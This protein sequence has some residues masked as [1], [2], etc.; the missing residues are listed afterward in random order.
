MDAPAAATVSERRLIT[1]L[2]AD[3]VGFTAMSEHLDPEDVS[4]LL[5]LYFTRCR[6]L[7]ER[8]GGTVEKFIGDAVMAVWGSPVA[9]EDDAERAVRAALEL[10]RGVRALAEEVGR[11]ELQVRAGV[12]TGTAAVNV[13]QEA[14]GMVL[15]D[16]VNTASRLQSLAAPGTVLVDDV[17]RRVSEAA[18]VYEDAGTHQVKGRE[19]PVRAWTALRVVAGVG[20]ARRAVGLE[21]P[22]VGRDHE[23]QT[24]IDAGERSAREGCAERV[25]VI[26]GAGSGKSR[27]LWEHFKYVDG[28]EE[29]RWW[30]QGRCLSYGEGVAYSALAEAIRGRAG[31]LEEEDPDS[32]REKLRA[33]T[34][35]F[36]HDERER[37]LVLPRLAH[38]LALE[39]RIATDPADLFSGWR[40]FFERMAETG[41]VILAF[42]DLQWATEGML[43]FIDYLLE[44][45][46]EFPIFI[47]ALTRPELE[48]RRP[49]LGTISRLGALEEQQMLELLDGLAPGLPADLT[50]RILERAEGIPL[51]G[52]E[53]VRMLLDLGM[54]ELE[55]SRYVPREIGDLDVPESLQALAAARLDELAPAERTLLQH[56]AVLGTSFLPEALAFVSERLEAD[57]RE[58]LE[59]LRTKQVLARVDDQRLAEF[60]QYYFLQALIKTVALST[61]SRRERKARHLAAAAYIRTNLQETE[62]A[63]LLASHYLAAVEQD[64]E[65]PDADAIRA[66][67]CETLATAGRHAGSLALAATAGR[68]LEQA[69][70]LASTELERAHLL[71][72]AGTAAA[73]SVD[74]ERAQAL[75]SE[76]IEIFAGL[77][78]DE[79]QAR[80]QALVADVLIAEAQLDEAAALMDSARKSIT[81]PGVLAEVA[82]RRA[83]VAI[84]TGEYSRAYEEAEAALAI[85]DPGGQ[86]AIVAD[87]ALSKAAV[88]GFQRRLTEAAGI[89]ALGLQLGLDGEL[90]EPALRGYHNLAVFR[91]GAGQ[92][93]EALELVDRGLALARER[94]D[95]SW[96][97]YLLAQRI[98]LRV[99]HGEWDDAL[100]EG[101][102]LRRGAEDAAERVGW[103]AR[104]L[105]L[106][107]RG[108]QAALEEWLERE[109]APSE[110]AEQALDDEIARAVALQA[111][112]EAQQAAAIAAKAWVEM[113]TESGVG[114]EL[115]YLG[116]VIDILLQA[117][118]LDALASGI[119]P[120]AKHSMP[121]QAG[122]F[123]WVRGL[124]HARHGEIEEA[125][126]A[127]HEA[128]RALRA[129]EHPY[130][131]ARALLDLGVSLA[132]SGSVR[133]A[134]TALGEARELYAALRAVPW[135]ARAEEA[136]AP[137]ASVRTPG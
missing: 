27:L 111:V 76:A 4:E 51:Y 94:G 61:L 74:R 69:A 82:A 47:L 100:A 117:G 133:E 53:I 44:W 46:A 59:T 65:A 79:D 95:R 98:T 54:L 73:R 112:G 68:Y 37:R 135:L 124:L 93:R 33:V 1:V 16:T 72:E 108:E 60:G 99:H 67:A 18:I 130:R 106:A 22:F 13:G 56:A 134:E 19:Q 55:G 103:A 120:A 119:A 38:L 34:E 15:G 137:M 41:A 64:P 90:S 92:P 11:P 132:A 3:L 91:I 39:E 83:H 102:S 127:L 20:G 42:E 57:V 10:T 70:E 85:A 97:R 2:F 36:V 113:Q 96:E 104:P 17:T 31:I 105:M 84:L 62:A 78:R 128:V 5:S 8:H 109:L 123:A 40:L 101:D 21:A 107:A 131:L 81:D 63:E 7:I 118:E 66:N 136:L 75:L 121:V 88:L 115:Y 9:R 122:E 114:G 52:V 32:A 116:E 25:T 71:A 29:A 49:L 87:A 125:H 58:S 77:G 26:G 110:W 12:L 6:S 45:S 35:R 48:E 126:A 14:E 129:V 28:I 23:L 43:D 89:C 80:T 86:L 50:G 30:H 24:I